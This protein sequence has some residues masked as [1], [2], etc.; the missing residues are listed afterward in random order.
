MLFSRVTIFIACTC[1]S[2]HS[3]AQ[4]VPTMQHFTVRHG[5]AENKVTDGVMTPD[6]LYWFTTGTEINRFDGYGFTVFP[7][8]TVQRRETAFPS[9]Q[10]TLQPDGNIMT[11]SGM[12]GVNGIGLF[13]TLTGAFQVPNWF[14]RLPEKRRVLA[15]QKSNDNAFYV[16]IEERGREGYHLYQ[17]V[18]DSL[19]YRK[20]LTDSPLLNLNTGEPSASIFRVF[21]D[22]IW[23]WLPQQKSILVS[24]TQGRILKTNRS[25]WVGNVEKTFPEGLVLPHF[26]H[27]ARGMWFSDVINGIFLHYDAVSQRWIGVPDMPKGFS[28]NTLDQ[29]G[30]FLFTSTGATNQRIACYFPEEN[31]WQITDLPQ[32]TYFGFVGEDFRRS[33]FGFGAEGLVQFDFKA[34]KTQQYLTDGTNP[35]RGMSEMKDGSVI[36]G[37]EWTGLY[38]I[39]PD[40]QVQSFSSIY[41]SV[42]L[43]VRRNHISTRLVADAQDGIWFGMEHAPGLFRLDVEQRTLRKYAWNWTLFDFLPVSDGRVL[44]GSSCPGLH[45][46]DPVSGQISLVLDTIQCP[47]LRENHVYSMLE[48]PKGHVWLGTTRGVL[49]FD[50]TTKRVLDLPGLNAD[51]NTASVTCMA[52]TP[53][54]MLWIG[55]LGVGLVGYDAATGKVVS[56]D[57]Q[58]GLSNS[59]IA[60]IV[61]DGNN[62][63][64]STYFGMSY[65]SAATRA[66]TNFYE[67]DGISHNEFNRRSYL[68]TRDGRVWLGGLRGLTVFHPSEFFDS[69]RRSSRVVPVA[70]AFFKNNEWFRQFQGLE[71]IEE[72]YLPPT[73]RRCE[74]TFTLNDLTS[75]ANNQF[76]YMLEGRD[77]EWHLLGTQR[78]IIFD[79]L[80]SGEYTLLVKAA[81]GAGHWSEP[82]RL[83][84]RVGEVFY[85][86]WY[87]WAL[88]LTLVLGLGMWLGELYR[89]R[90]AERREAVRLREL[91]EFKTRLYD[92]ITHEFRT[93]LTLLLGPTERALRRLESFTKTELAETLQ[94][95]QRNGT[96]LLQ[97]VNQMLDLR[98]LDTG[99]IDIQ[100]VQGD[101]MQW[102]QYIVS[103]FESLAADR[104]VQLVFERQPLALQMDYDKDKLLKILNNLL[105]NALKFTPPDGRVTVSATAMN[106]T[107]E[108]CVWDNGVGIEAAD[109]PR[110]FE[111]YF[112]SASA[113]ASGSG[114]GLALVK[115]LAELLGGDVR[116]ESAL[117]KG[118]AFWVRL[119]IRLSAVKTD[120]HAFEAQWLPAQPPLKPAPEP[121]LQENAPLALIVED[122]PEVA[123]FVASC[124]SSEYRIELAANGRVG[125]EKALNLI[126][127]LV[128]T[129]LMM[130]EMD[131]FDLTEKL[132]NDERS[133]HIPIILLTARSEVESRL[134]G[135]R[136]GADAYLSKPFQEEE[137]QIIAAQEI[138][139]RQR[140]RQ[141]FA[142]L[143]LPD[144]AAEPISEAQPFDPG[145]EDAFFV[146][147]LGVI[148]ANLADPAFDVPRLSRA[149]LL[150][151][152][153]LQRKLSALT[154]QSALQIIR[155]LRLRHAQRLLRETD[156]PVSEVAW[157]SGFADPSYFTRIFTRDQGMAPSDWR[158][159]A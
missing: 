71:Q 27:T 68:R 136:R 140:L 40:G 2:V 119:P 133:S 80:P 135:L 96:Q 152:S 148:E 91:D 37:A 11:T 19:H 154:D 107:L 51:W 150:S 76:S 9:R 112:Q 125:V 6:G 90:A 60:G 97:L 78:Q 81:D 21:R 47:A 31:R 16:I 36:V 128:V 127:D 33:F 93:P 42:E 3:R 132:K 53:D 105:S 144:A 145:R 67:E 113:T 156:L 23:E 43:N 104:Q 46:L 66:F 75:A 89:R 70:F 123:R 85:K 14:S 17:L 73:Q 115:E 5:L 41:D 114:I 1:L 103:S 72:L 48:S 56:Y 12:W 55:T 142:T 49:A 98:K 120:E 32:Y 101:V 58:Q 131:G 146:K 57:R 25:Y 63:W 108:I 88:M 7:L 147:V 28:I 20:R 157:A 8:N 153:Q 118:A 50:P 13:S 52:E 94:T 34:N 64:I 24:T 149:V 30:N 141:R 139:L 138:R 143:V 95:V 65:F 121:F 124:L 15:I 79:W 54:G 134:E 99:K 74:M 109:Q 44:F 87:F 18:S 69:Q 10:L 158:E 155:T 35:I 84:I 39:T 59:K 82:Y 126:P 111:R 77:E 62:L 29:K 159:K 61:S 22:T 86:T 116:V 45:S 122:N 4:P 26:M 117:G 106:K 151:P 38:K 130:P 137:L 83:R 92:G 110:L 100:Y 102:L 129:D